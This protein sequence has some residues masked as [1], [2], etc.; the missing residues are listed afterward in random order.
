MTFPETLNKIFEKY[1][2]CEESL[3]DNLKSKFPNEYKFEK[4]FFRG[5]QQ[6]G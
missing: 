2:I 6:R 5:F 4:Y 1:N 3:V